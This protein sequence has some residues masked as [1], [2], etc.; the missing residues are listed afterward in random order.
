[1]LRETDFYTTMIYPDNQQQSLSSFG[2]SLPFGQLFQRGLTPQRFDKICKRVFRFGEGSFGVSNESHCKSIDRSLHKKWQNYRALQRPYPSR[3][4]TVVQSVK[5]HVLTKP[6][7]VF[8]P[9]ARGSLLVSDKS[10]CI[11]FYSSLPKKQLGHQALPRPCVP[12]RG[13]I[14]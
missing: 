2:K 6:K 13:R 14:L 7:R 9:L 10:H 4:G 12:R 3:T 1:M 5:P 11:S 8:R